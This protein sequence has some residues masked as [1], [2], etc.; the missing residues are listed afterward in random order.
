M[1]RILT[2]SILMCCAVS[3]S[4]ATPHRAIAAL[5]CPSYI[6]KQGAS[7]VC[8]VTLKAAEAGDVFVSLTPD[9]SFIVVPVTVRISAGTTQALF[10]LVAVQW[11]TGQLKA[12]YGDSKFITITVTP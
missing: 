8:T 10:T 12:T 11:Q 3:A 6:L 5:D 1:K 7:E 4:A 2:I 9:T